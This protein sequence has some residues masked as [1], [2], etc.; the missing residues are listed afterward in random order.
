MS[1]VLYYPPHSC[2]L[3]I[4]V[5]DLNYKALRWTRSINSHVQLPTFYGIETVGKKY[6][7]CILHLWTGIHV[8]IMSQCNGY[9]LGFPSWNRWFGEVD[10]MEIDV[11]NTLWC[12]WPFLAYSVSSLSYAV[13][14]LISDLKIRRL[15][16]LKAHSKNS[17]N[18]WLLASPSLRWVVWRGCASVSWLK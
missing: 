5:V 8:S 9:S 6:M 14:Y 11:T 7:F 17:S 2:E 16:D 15:K 10:I 4:V 13:Q 1:H 3:R 12:C 18:L